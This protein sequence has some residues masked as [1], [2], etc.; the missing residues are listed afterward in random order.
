MQQ[1][2]IAPNNKQE[3]VEALNQQLLDSNHALETLRQQQTA[4]EQTQAAKN[5][6]V[7]S[8]E[9]RLRVGQRAHIDSS[10]VIT[11]LQERL[12]VSER[13]IRAQHQ[14]HVWR[15]TPA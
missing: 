7:V 5:K 14:V 3:Q 6:L 1:L 9:S 2:Y 10:N 15:T 4:S 13:T 12:T 8:L 11:S